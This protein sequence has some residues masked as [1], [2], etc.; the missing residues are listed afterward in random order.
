VPNILYITANDFELLFG[1][2]QDQTTGYTQVRVNDGLASLFAISSQGKSAYNV[3]E[4]LLEENTYCIE[5]ITITSIPIY[6]L[7]PNVRIEV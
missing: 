6:Y 7:K 3:L 5:N 2:E 1:G 4:K